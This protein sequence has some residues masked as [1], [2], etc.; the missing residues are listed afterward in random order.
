VAAERARHPGAAVE[1]WAF[2]T[3]TAPASYGFRVNC[4]RPKR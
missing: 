4:S 3:S 1:V 2:E